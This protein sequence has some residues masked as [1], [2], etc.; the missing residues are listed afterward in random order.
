MLRL[1]LAHPYQL[2]DKW[3]AKSPASARQLHSNL[4]TKT[5]AAKG[6]YPSKSA[7]EDFSDFI[8]DVCEILIEEKDPNGNKRSSPPERRAGPEDGAYIYDTGPGG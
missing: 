7:M 1:L 3:Y 2:Y 4:I 5:Y 6:A 8:G